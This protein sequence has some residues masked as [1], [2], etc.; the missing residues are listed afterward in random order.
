MEL[1]KTKSVLCDCLK[2][3]GWVR[4]CV[5][6]V[7]VWLFR[8]STMQGLGTLISGW[9]ACLASFWSMNESSMAESTI[10]GTGSEDSP[11]KRVP[12]RIRRDDRGQVEEALASTPTFAGEIGLLDCLCLPIAVPWLCRCCEHLTLNCANHSG[13]PTALIS[14]CFTSSLSFLFNSPEADDGPLETGSARGFFSWPL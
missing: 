2:R 1:W 5:E 4:W 11:Q 14:F 9:P 10:R 12:Y 3:G 8:S 13:L 7:R 6:R